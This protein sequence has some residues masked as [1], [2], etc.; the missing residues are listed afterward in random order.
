MY[1][2]TK[3]RV[4]MKNTK[5]EEPKAPKKRDL[6]GLRRATYIVAFACMLAIGAYFY[7]MVDSPDLAQKVLGTFGLA[8]AVHYFV[9]AIK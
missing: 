6:A 4:G 1:I 5:K 9:L 3:E 7:I 2:P 8:S